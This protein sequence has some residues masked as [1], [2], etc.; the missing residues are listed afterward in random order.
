[1]LA[2]EYLIVFITPQKKNFFKNNNQLWLWY[3]YYGSNCS[4]FIWLFDITNTSDTICNLTP[5]SY[6]WLS[7]Y[8]ASFLVFGPWIEPWI[9]P[10]TSLLINLQFMLF[11][12]YVWFNFVPLQNFLWRCTQIERWILNNT[13]TRFIGEKS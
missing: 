6:L 4:M 11:Y 5:I 1:M 12:K 13:W 2:S 8:M 10:R 7:W 3:Y 9:E